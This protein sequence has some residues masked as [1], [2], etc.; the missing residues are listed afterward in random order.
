MAKV[1][2]KT[3]VFSPGGIAIVYILTAFLG[4]M[5]FRYIFPPE[6]APLPLF[7][8]P[9]RFIRGAEDF[10]RLFPALCLSA[11][12]L[13]FGFR[14]NLDL[15]FDS[16]SRR[17]SEIF[18]GHIFT[19]IGMSTVYGLL[20]LVVLPLMQD[21]EADK[22][23]Q[24][25]L[26]RESQSK[27]RAYAAEE[28]WIEAARMVALCEG[29][30]PE[31]P[32]ME[33]LKQDVYV[34]LE[35]YN[36]L[37]SGQDAAERES[38]LPEREEGGRVL[39]QRNPVDAR[40][41]LN[42]AETA[43]AEE[44]YYDA[45]W[46][47]F[48][49][50]RIARPGS[51]E[52]RTAA[53]LASKAWNAIASL[54]PNSREAQAYSRYHLKRSGYEAMAAEDWIRGYYIFKEYAELSPGD[55]DVINFIKLCEGGIGGIAF[56]TDEIELAVGEIL[57]GALFSLPRRTASG[58]ADGRV[59]ARIRSLSAFS[60]TSYGIDAELM[61]FD[62]DGRLLYRLEAPYVKMTPITLD[63]VPRVALL[64]R[65][66]DRHNRN[67]RWEPR[68][69]GPERP[70]LGDAQLILDVSYR[71]FLLLARAR[72]G[73]DNF[74]LGD[75]FEAE[76]RLGSLGY[77]P[78]VF[79]A[80]IVRRLAEPALFLPLTILVIVMG[81][82]Y[83]AKRRPRYMGLPLLFLLPLVFNGLAH[84]YRGMI[85]ALSVLMALSLSFSLVIPFF[86]AGA[87]I[88]FIGALLILAA[89]HG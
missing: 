67:L 29:I 72:R 21:M 35:T 32:E 71:D 53:D 50:R 16:F 19:A 84:I 82:R 6:A 64:M 55:P 79:Q 1:S 33:R 45:H 69:D 70:G 52:T 73:P 38:P 80:L 34:N 46:L 25:H 85:R 10:I 3:L 47:A 8:V 28:A 40:E 30:W 88:L 27:A 31:S 2:L 42:F 39:G 44:R 43:F 87:L 78:Q 15:A 9:W 65:A 59:V 49:A 57:T 74:L 13:P 62:R 36:I 77:A 48:L 7:S 75:L 17:F 37:N 68:W 11:L 54:E 51:V 26:F 12:V 5:G 20:F 4:I 86:I 61:A 58:L 18:R 14:N 22:R 83:R 56:F 89:Q 23:F 60:D 24:G 66:L 41:A 76:K 81:W 63:G